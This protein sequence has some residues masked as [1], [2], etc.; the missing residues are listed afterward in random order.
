M[1]Q[2]SWRLRRP[3]RAEGAEEESQG[4]SR[5]ALPRSATLRWF[6]N[7][8][9]LRVS[10][11]TR[12]LFKTW[13]DMLEGSQLV[14]P[15]FESN[16][17]TFAPDRLWAVIGTF[18]LWAACHI[19]DWRYQQGGTPRDRRKADAELRRNLVLLMFSQGFAY[20][21]SW[22]YWVVVRKAGRKHFGRPPEGRK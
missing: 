9:P 4:L 6:T 11:E 2:K 10:G 19:H 16:G 17:C 14:P 21:L 15:G 13:W 20:T 8:V 18:S 7:R 3:K 12:L 22:V 5:L 1:L